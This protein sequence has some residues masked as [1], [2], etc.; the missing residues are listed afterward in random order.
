MTT[1]SGSTAGSTTEATLKEYATDAERFADCLVD[2]VNMASGDTYVLRC[3]IKV[4]SGGSYLKF[5]ESSL[6]GAQDL[7]PFY[8]A[9]MSAKFGVKWTIQK[10][11]GTDRTFKW[12][13]CEVT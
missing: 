6:S 11:A 12:K 1:T 3:Y 13:S 5:S 8:F 4:E 9:L 10:T 7:P 2:T